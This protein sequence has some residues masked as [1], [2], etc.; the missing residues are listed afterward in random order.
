MW[1]HRANAFCGYVLGHVIVVGEQFKLALIMLRKHR[2]NEVR[3]GMLAKVRR[4]VA[5]AQAT[6]GI[7]LQDRHGKLRIVVLLAYRSLIFFR[8]LFMLVEQ[9]H[10]V[11]MRHKVGNEKII[12]MNQCILRSEFMRGFVIH[13]RFDNFSLLVQ[14]ARQIIE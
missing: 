1:N 11:G 8:E 4:E 13:Q 12:A 5:N 9:G 2:L 14:D 3:H 7:A 10:G 6:V